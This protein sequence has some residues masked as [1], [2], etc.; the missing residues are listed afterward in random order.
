MKKAAGLSGRV[1]P[2]ADEAGSLMLRDVSH[3]N[4]LGRCRFGVKGFR[5]LYASHQHSA[6]APVDGFVTALHPPQ[7]LPN[8]EPLIQEML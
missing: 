7:R 8:D 6:D 3:V 1:E 4:V 2:D 5:Q